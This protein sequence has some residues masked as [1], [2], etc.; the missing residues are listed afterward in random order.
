MGRSVHLDI[1]EQK[2]GE[3]IMK[4]R[5]RIANSEPDPKQ[6]YWESYSAR[7]VW[8][9]LHDCRGAA[10]RIDTKS[11]EAMERLTHVFQTLLNIVSYLLAINDPA[12]TSAV[13]HR[14]MHLR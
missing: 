14:T 9:W 1:L 4:E 3:R 10:E 8:R 11:P 13:D 12:A 7:T 6:R 5:D 2:R